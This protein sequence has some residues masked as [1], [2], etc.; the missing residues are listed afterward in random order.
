M[1][2]LDERDPEPHGR[3]S[4]RVPCD[5]R[6]KRRE[7]VVAA[8]VEGVGAL[9]L[10]QADREHLHQPALDGT[11]EAGVGLDA[12]DGDDEVGALEGV[13]IHEHRDARDDLAEVHGL[14]RGADLAAHGLGRDPVAGQDGELALGGRAPVAAHRRDDEHVRA[15]FPET[16]DD[17]AHHLVDAVDAAAAGGDADAGPR[18]DRA[19][20]VVHRQ[21]HRRRH[22]VDRRRVQVLAHQ[23]PAGEDGR[24]ELGV[25]AAVH[26][27]MMPP[28]G[29]N[30]ARRVGGVDATSTGRAAA[31]TTPRRDVALG[32]HHI[33]RSV[34][35]GELQARPNDDPS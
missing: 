7:V 27:W 9:L 18:P 3:P 6:D 32:G 15:R 2:V 11:R 20:D 5:G 1:P 26:A 33:M 34:E 13:A 19:D 31:Q 21:A 35:R 16:P 22:I 29:A 17:G 24:K 8:P 14:H 25:G 30:R 10:A 4:D 12:V 23:R 28:R